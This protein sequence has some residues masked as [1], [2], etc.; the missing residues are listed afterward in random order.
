MTAR[1]IKTSTGKKY[2]RAGQRGR[3]FKH[4]GKNTSDLPSFEESNVEDGRVKV[5]KLK[6]VHLDGQ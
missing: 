1:K 6:Q 5:D 3:G 4:E 2:T